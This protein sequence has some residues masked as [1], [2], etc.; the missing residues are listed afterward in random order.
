MNFLL[1]PCIRKCYLVAEASHHLN[2]PPPDPPKAG[3]EI[4]RE[5][6]ADY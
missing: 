5:S 1:D 3:I 4:G 6:F 2:P